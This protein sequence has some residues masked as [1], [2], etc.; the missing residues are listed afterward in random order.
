MSPLETGGNLMGYWSGAN[1]AV[2]TQ[3]VGPGPDAVHAP[4]GFRP[5]YDFQEREIARIFRGT[6][7]HVT[8][9]GD[10][11][12]HP[13]SGAAHLSTKDRK[14]IRAIAGSADAQAPRP[15]TILLTG[16]PDDWGVAAW[17]AELGRSR[18]GWRRLVLAAATLKFSQ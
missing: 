7:G 10:W 11:H 9:L 3:I 2:V 16:G 12:T 1:E 18:L 5:D 4:Y 14:T 17:S 6:A 8:Y 13:G 15:L